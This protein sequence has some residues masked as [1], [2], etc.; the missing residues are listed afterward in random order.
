[1]KSQILSWEGEKRVQAKQQMERKKVSIEILFLLLNF[2]KLIKFM[3]QL[4]NELDYTRA[5]AIEHYKR[6]IARI[7]MIGQRAIKELEDNRRK[8]EI[9]VKEK[10]NKIRK[11][12][13]VPVTCFCFKS[14]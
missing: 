2:M 5:N 13:K 11:T 6:K 7:D 4:Q 8:E 3:M 12:G 14:L 10:A 9:K 1:M